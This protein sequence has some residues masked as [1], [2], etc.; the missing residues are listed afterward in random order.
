[1]PRSTYSCLSNKQSDTHVA[2]LETSRPQKR[3]KHVRPGQVD[4][5]EQPDKFLV[6]YLNN[7]GPEDKLYTEAVQSF[8][9]SRLTN[10]TVYI[11]EQMEELQQIS[12]RLENPISKE[13]IAEQIGLYVIKRIAPRVDGE[14]AVAILVEGLVNSLPDLEAK[15]RVLMPWV[16]WDLDE[17]DATDDETHQEV[18]D[19]DVNAESAINQL[20]DSSTQAYNMLPSLT[21]RCEVIK[22]IFHGVNLKTGSSSHGSIDNILISPLLNVAKALDR[23]QE[24]MRRAELEPGE[25]QSTKV[26]IAKLTAPNGEVAAGTTGEQSTTLANKI[27]RQEKGA[28]MFT[29]AR[30][31]NS[32]EPTLQDREADRSSV[33][34]SPALSAR[35]EEANEAQLDNICKHGDCSCH[36]QSEFDR[37][38]FTSSS[39][40]IAELMTELIGQEPQPEL[41]TRHA[42]AIVTWVKIRRIGR[43]CHNYRTSATFPTPDLWFISSPPIAGSSPSS[44]IPHRY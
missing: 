15:K 23:L 38:I 16:D 17:D 25:V 29:R 19:T 13:I 30:I 31:H 20:V 34:I 6:N 44:S 18:E 39:R 5:F 43:R 42:H 27:A 24:T 12:S 35:P 1:M 9:A 36:R 10:P 22:K 21:A 37:A 4:S 40:P 41:A 8:V 33:I 7:Y 11:K 32:T 2:P 28:E 26:A 3:S 14:K